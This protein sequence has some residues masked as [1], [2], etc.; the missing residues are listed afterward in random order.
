APRHNTESRSFA[1]ASCNGFM[2]SSW[3][4]RRSP[5]RFAPFYHLFQY[6]PIPQRVHRSPEA[7]VLVAHEPTCRNEPAKWLKY[8]FLTISNVFEN[9]TAKNKVT[10]VNP[11]IELLSRA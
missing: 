8:K 4:P 3:S 9:L 5:R 10:T 2:L 6:L 1:V 7:L 11:G